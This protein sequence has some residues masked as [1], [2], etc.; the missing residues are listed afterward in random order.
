[1]HYLIK[2]TTMTRAIIALSITACLA[3]GAHAES[4]HLLC[5]GTT[6]EIADG[7][8]HNDIYSIDVDTDFRKMTVNAD[9]MEQMRW[10]PDEISGW[11]ERPERIFLPSSIATLG[12]SR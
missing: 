6:T 8:R 9:I 7:K 10:G 2:G 3:S 4:I 1:M 11:I 5:T 12:R